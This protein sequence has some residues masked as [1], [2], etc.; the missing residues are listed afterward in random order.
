MKVKEHQGGIQKTYSVGST[1]YAKEMPRYFL[2]GYAKNGI[3]RGVWKGVGS[4]KSTGCLEEMPRY[5]KLSRESVGLVGLGVRGAW[6]PGCAA[7][8]RSSSW[9]T[10]DHGEFWTVLVC[11]AVRVVPYTIRLSGSNGCV[12]YF[13]GGGWGCC[14]LVA[15]G[16]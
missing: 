5:E 1:G 15:F 7:S 12:L 11:G 10:A 13:W 6:R 14:G 9:Q 16:S 2:F 3:A 4:R 8:R